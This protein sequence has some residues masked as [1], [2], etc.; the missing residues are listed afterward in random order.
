[1]TKIKMRNILI[2]LTLI[3]ISFNYSFAQT[4]ILFDASKAE[5]AGNADWVIDA[6]LNNLGYFNG[7]AQIGGTESNAQ[8]T[9]TPLQA[10]ITSTTSETAWS[11]GISAWGID[12]VKKGYTVESLPYNGQITYGQS[13]NAQ[14]LTN[15]KVFIIC[16]PNI[17]FTTAQKTAMMQFIQNGGGLFI[18][19][20]HANSD[21]NGDGYDSQ[22]IWNDFLLNNPI[23]NNPFGFKFDSVDVSQI[24]TNVAS[25][26]TDTL[27]H[28]PYGNVTSLEY[29]NGATLTLSPANNANVRG[30]IYKNGSST[31]GNTNAMMVRSRYGLGKIAALGDSSPVD[32]GTGDPNDALYDGYISG[33]SGNHR[34]LIM[35]TTFWLVNNT[36]TG[37]ES[38]EKSSFNVFPNPFVNELTVTLS[39]NKKTIFEI[40]D[41]SGNTVKSFELVGGDSN[42][43]YLSN[44]DPGMYL[45]QNKSN[46]S[47]CKKI[48]K[49]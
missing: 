27:L 26:A 37:I 3:S 17:L 19:C 14:D 45:I 7:P 24:S 41:L 25:L 43:I 12:C 15:Y 2:L 8:R 28:G 13:S 5:A 39:E 20:D 22:M 38:I 1:M 9:P 48:I 44:L 29:N 10:T 4:K 16:E 42:T 18:I 46:K 31:T 35:N 49:F 30:V 11:G 40:L 34:K 47:D 23:Q 6:D 33:A 32:D 36:L 21:R